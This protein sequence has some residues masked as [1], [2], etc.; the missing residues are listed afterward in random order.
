VNRNRLLL[1]A[2]AVGA[3][4]VVGV[5]LIVV[6]TGGSS[7]SSSTTAGTTTTAPTSGSASMFAGIPQHGDTLGK[8]SA[9]ATM[10]VFEDPQCPY[11]RQFSLDALP[12]VLDQFVRTGRLKLVYRGV[13]VIGPNSEKGLRATYAAGRQDKLWN[14]AE[15][16]YMRQ[17]AENSGWITEG[18]IREAAVAAGAKPAAVLAAASSAAV[19][20]A[21]R[22]AAQQA[23]AGGVDGTPTFLVQR[24]PS[25]PQQLSVTALDAATF[26]ASLAA[27]LQ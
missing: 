8:A 20:G 23:I 4:A 27:A 2:G 22:Q 6:G 17:G 9:P 3:A 21:L 19:T 14:L 11:C 18:V 1:L 16:L 10:I 5:L 13:E 26:T 24:P 7:G 15:Q 25:R 12:G